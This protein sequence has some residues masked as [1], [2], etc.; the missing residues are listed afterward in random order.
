VSRLFGTDG[1][2]ALAN[3]EPLT[4]ELAFRLGRQL[5]ATLLEHHRVDKL[6]LVVGRDTRQSGPM[7][8]GALV[9]GALSAGADV[10]AVGV[11]PT[12]GI[13][14]VTRRL[15]AHGGVVISASHNPFEDN[16][17]KI[18]S[19]T[20]SKFPDTWEDEIESRLGQPDVAPKPTGAAVGRLVPHRHASEA[21]YAAYAVGTVAFD[22]RGLHIVMD[23]ANGATYRVAPRVFETLGARVTILGAEPDGQNINLDC[24]ALHPEGV[25]ERVRATGA[26]L[27]LAF[28]GDGDRLICVDEL[29]EVRD[30]DYVLAVCARHLAATDRLLGGVLVTTVMANLG[31]EHSL[32]QAGIRTVKTQVGDRYV[33]EEMVRIGANLGGEQSGHLLFLDHASTG[34]GIV[35]A[36]QLLAVMRETGQ[37]LSA[38]AACLTKFPQVLVNVP[39]RRKPPFESIEGL[40][41]RRQALEGWLN[42]AGRILLRYSG[43][44]LLARVMVEGQEQAEIEKIAHELA[45]IIRGAIGQ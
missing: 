2:R 7:L 23:C 34:D 9:S 17:I 33:L 3:A 13:A 15:D 45:G 16:G 22:L 42:G 20:G 14:H 40:A 18:F 39:V 8:E 29:G 10:Y 5:V 35:S 21:E 36:L 28:D 31:L 43:T 19:S 6:R 4:T 11:L 32:R 27:G 1:I 41:A 24:G 38:L 25:Q 37:P 30:G 26:D 12:P 44:E